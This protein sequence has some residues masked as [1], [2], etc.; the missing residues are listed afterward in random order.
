MFVARAA[1]SCRAIHRQTE[2]PQGKP[3]NQCAKQSSPKE[4]R[5]SRRFVFGKH[6]GP[7]SCWGIHRDTKTEVSF[8][9][10]ESGVAAAIRHPLFCQDPLLGCFFARCVLAGECRE[11]KGKCPEKR[12][13][14]A[15]GALRNIITGNVLSRLLCFAKKD[16]PPAAWVPSDGEPEPSPSSWISVIWA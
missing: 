16:A 5:L 14:A 11:D 10:P 2:P 3:D 6:G 1:P 13:R 15:D 12:R 4:I 7:R 8:I 9:S